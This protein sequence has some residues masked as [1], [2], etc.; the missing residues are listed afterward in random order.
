MEDGGL[1]SD[2][3][4]VRVEYD[5]PQRSPAPHFRVY[6]RRWFMLLV[7][8]LLNCSNSV[9]WLTF[10]PIADQTAENLH[11]TL[12]LVNWLSLV[13]MVVAIP[14]S[15]ITIWMLDKLGLQPSMI[16]GSWLNM[17]GSVMK[18]VGVLSYLPDYTMFPVVMTGQTLCSLAQ[19][20]VVFTP[21]KL[22]ALW[23]PEHQRATANMIASMSNPLGLLFVN[24]LSP[25]ILSR[26]NSL[27]ILLL[28]YAIPA[29]IVCFLATVGI[30]KS[31]PPTPPSASAD[32]SSS[33]PFLQG[34][35]LLVTNKAYLILLVCFGSGIGI[36]TCFS[37]LLEQIL[38]VK[39][40]SND[41][42][43]LCGALFIVSGVFGAASIGFFV[44][45]TK[46]FTESIKISMCLTSLACTAFAVVSQLAE[47]KVVIGVVCA[48][49]G[50]F[51]F[52]TYPVAMELSVECSYP[53]GEATSAGLVFISGQIQSI[54]YT[55]LLPALTEKLTDSTLSVCAAGEDANLNWMVSVLVMAGLCCLASCSF[56]IFFH[57]QYRRL[58]KEADAAEN[59]STDT[60][61]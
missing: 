52:A 21:T 13:Y 16:L 28:I 51:G 37:T 11:V 18:V 30:Q 26:T 54:V 61:E 55:A 43:G 59:H 19:P 39:G 48:L 9:Q 23:F 31:I 8:C 50:L 17:A 14:L 38:C 6:K 46:M 60:E 49:F 1:A 53:V 22:A 56:V 45:K 40:Y 12:E 2:S 47:Q 36:F 58:D 35:K 29:V 10:A 7:L 33:E 32:T 15:F 20:L 4:E 57:T 42:A 41:F 44:D 25:M 3:S 24:I 27:F 34:I 5:S